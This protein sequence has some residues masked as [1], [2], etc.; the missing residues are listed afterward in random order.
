[1]AK[2][3]TRI[4]DLRELRDEAAN[5]IASALADGDGK[6]EPG[7]WTGENARH[8]WEHAQAHLWGLNEEFN[9]TDANHLVCRAVM[10]LATR[11]R[12]LSGK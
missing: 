3:R 1:M 7:S 9:E 4:D 6:H 11:R 10:L 5:A 12:L 2:P 8:H